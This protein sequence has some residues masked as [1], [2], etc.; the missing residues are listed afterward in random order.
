[1]IFVI[2]PRLYFSSLVGSYFLTS[3][4]CPPHQNANCPSLLIT[5]AIKISFVLLQIATI[6][7]RMMET[8]LPCMRRAC[9]LPPPLL[10]PSSTNQFKSSLTLPPPSTQ[11]KCT[12]YTGLQSKQLQP[13][14]ALSV[15]SSVTNSGKA[16]LPP[17]FG[18]SCHLLG[19]LY[20]GA[21]IRRHSW[22]Q[23]CVSWL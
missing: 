18:L 6:V 23:T 13:E 14:V 8:I 7:M 1:M 4:H 22:Y 17:A 5:I 15:A 20:C 12:R 21:C 16:T 9:R 11:L 19:K 2:V 3:S 10:C